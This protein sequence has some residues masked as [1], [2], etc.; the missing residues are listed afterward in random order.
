MSL[1]EIVKSVARQIPVAV[2]TVAVG[3]TDETAQSLLA[4]ALWSARRIHKSHGWLALTKE[5]TFATLPGVPD[6]GLPTD[7]HRL[8]G[9]TAWDRKDFERLQGPLSPEDWQLIKSGSLGVSATLTRFRLKP[10]ATVSRVFLDPTPTDGRTLVY[11]YVS[12]NWCK[13][14]GGAEQSAW[15]AD[16]DEPII[17]AELVELGTL[18]RALRRLG[19][20]YDEEMAEFEEQLALAMARDGGGAKVLS[21]IPREFGQT[22]LAPGNTPETGFGT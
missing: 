6:Y 16:L 8:I 9:E 12:K 4:A 21:I 5:F 13:S 18:A 3:S 11:E 22:Y 7:Y 2:P 15:L 20:S 10:S 14:V 1:I 17:D 19:L